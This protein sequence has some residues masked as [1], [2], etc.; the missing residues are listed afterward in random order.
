VDGIFNLLV[1]AA[2]ERCYEIKYLVCIMF[3]ISGNTDTAYFSKRSL[4]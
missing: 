3:T 2:S 1:Q 4:K